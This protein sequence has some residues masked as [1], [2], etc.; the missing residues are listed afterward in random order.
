[1]IDELVTAAYD[2]AW[3]GGEMVTREGMRKAVDVVLTRLARPSA[4]MA[5]AGIFKLD[6]C[7]DESA[8]SDADGNMTS[9]TIIASDAPT[10]IFR[11][12]LEAARQ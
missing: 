6:D 7:Q 5:D 9:F 3:E 11:A 10:Q 1:M 12:M 8:S 2:A 4:Q